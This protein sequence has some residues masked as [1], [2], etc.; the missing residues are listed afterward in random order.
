MDYP[1]PLR[2]RTEEYPYVKETIVAVPRDTNFYVPPRK[3]S[4]VF[5]KRSND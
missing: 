2:P 4:N 5:F 3:N 1:S